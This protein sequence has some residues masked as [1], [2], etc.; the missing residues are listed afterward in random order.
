MDSIQVGGFR[1]AGLSCG[2]K[3]SG[4]ADLGLIVANA[5]VAC[6]GVFTTN[7]VVAAPVVQSQAR[8]HER[9]MARAI[10]VNSGNA[11]ACTGAQGE[12]DAR[13]MAALVAGVVGCV[14]RDVQVCSTGVIGAP[15]PMDKIESGLTPLMD[16]LRTDGLEDF[17][18]AICTTDTHRKVR[19]AH[20]KIGDRTVRVA[21][22]SKGAGM[23]H[24]NMATML[25]FVVTDAPIDPEDLKQIWKEVCA[26][27]FN[28]ITVDGD[29]STNDTA[30][31]MASGAAGGGP[32]KG[33][34][35]ASF[36]ALLLEVASELAK[37]IVRDAE[38]ATKLVEVVVS[39]ASCVQDAILASNAIAL[40][41]LVKT[42][43]H[44]EDPNWGRIVAAAGRSGAK[45]NPTAMCLWIGDVMLYENGAWL[46]SSAEA[47]AHQI[48]KR[49]EFSLRLDLG[50]GSV[51]RTVFTCDFSADYVRINADYRS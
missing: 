16:A 40:S 26:R 3:K 29:T 30:L 28:A 23:I 1:F 35:L 17:A 31:V 45:V 10:I 9:N 50:T 21:G 36:Q 8:L 6:A 12:A 41:P 43:I 39:G 2:I 18:D 15:L 27:S 32:L 7:Q 46:G 42:A 19:S 33:A 11:N 47:D 44:G 38:G 48:M 49:P 22:A 5:P 25:G 13:R 51:K 34:D 24:P 20:A 14:P 37:D 4:K